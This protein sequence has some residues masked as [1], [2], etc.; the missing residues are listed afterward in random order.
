MASEAVEE[1]SI[2]EFKRIDVRIGTIVEVE[3]I[4]G[5]D[6]LYRQK[7][8][9]GDHIRQIVSGLAE[10]YK[11]EELRGMRI[12]VVCNLKAAKIFGNIS[13]GM[14]LAAERDGK[15]ALLTTDREIPNGAKVT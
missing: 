9:M 2:R 4:P 3:K 8:D 1:I 14:L 7:V 10:Y 15:L 11:P 5:S 6:K 13:N 12:A